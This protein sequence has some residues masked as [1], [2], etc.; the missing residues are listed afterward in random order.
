MYP[1][2]TPSFNLT[3]ICKKKLWENLSLFDIFIIKQIY[4]E[5]SYKINGIRFDKI[6]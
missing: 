6:G 2:S 5:K 3:P 1:T 4:Y